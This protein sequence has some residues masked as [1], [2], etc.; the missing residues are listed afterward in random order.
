MR[1][2]FDSFTL[3]AVV[4]ELQPYVGGKVQRVVQPDALTIGLGL[5]ASGREAFLLL[6][7]DP[8][9]Y[10]A[11]FVTVRPPSSETQYGLCSSLRARADGARIL[12]VEQ[13]GFDRILKIRFQ[14]SD[15]EHELIAELMGKHSNLIFTEGDG[16]IV[17][18]A[19]WISHHKSVRPIQAGAKYEKPPFEKK[20]SLLTAKEGDN[21]KEFEGASPFL[22]SL[23]KA[24]GIS[25]EQVKNLASNGFAEAKPVLSIGNGAYPVSVKALG[26]EE[27]SRPAISVALEQHY[28]QA[29]PAAEAAA[30]KANL[31]ANLERVALA[32]EVA[33]QDLNQT[34]VMASKAGEMQLR[35]ELL[36][37]YAGSIPEGASQFESVDY[38][39]NPLIIK[40][41]PEKSTIENSNVY[42]DK[43]KR[44]KGRLGMVEDQMVRLSADLGQLESLLATVREESRI[45]KL[46]EFKDVA[47]G[48]RWLNRQPVPTRTKEER[49]YAGHK[50]REL[51]GPGGVTVLFGE[52]SESNDY[53]TLRVAKSN[54]WWLHIRGGT[55]CHVVIQT[56]NQPDKIGREALMFAAKVAV[57]HSKSKHS[58]YVS[59]DYTLKKYVRRPKGAPKGSVI[60]THEKTLSVEKG[61]PA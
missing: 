11:H 18:A 23:I 52:N 24:G 22:L 14:R 32:R 31:V 1:I 59:V 17:S 27:L 9:F 7:C 38:E 4:A 49:P 10:R 25:L 35:G 44:A 40:L 56:K 45:E 58:G 34:V 37:A 51:L 42:F 21:L 2:P 19:K 29:I 50:I 46:R 47:E 48:K 61:D 33:L 39:G 54:D 43:A 5:Y 15:S 60:Y 55:S 16:R 26:L 57:Q 30:L 12:S 41:D 28:A 3:A 6:N 20:P 36:L 13:V 8:N 53:L